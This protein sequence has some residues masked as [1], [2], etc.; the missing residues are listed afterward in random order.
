MPT[1]HLEYK[2]YDLSYEQPPQMGG[3]FQVFV[4]SNDRNLMAKIG[5]SGKIISGRDMED[6]KAN[7]RDFVDGL[8]AR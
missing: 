3:M 7:A 5:I 8:L 6:A 4:A 2:G 1:I